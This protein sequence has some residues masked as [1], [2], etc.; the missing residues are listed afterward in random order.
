M[1][2]DGS[3]MNVLM[4]AI[5]FNFLMENEFDDL[6]DSILEDARRTYSETTIEHFMDP[7]NLGPMDGADAFAEFHGPCGDTIG[8]WVKVKDGTLTDVRFITDGCGTSIASG[9]MI[10]EL[11]KGKDVDHAKKISQEDVLTALGGFPQEKE[12]CAMLAIM[13]LRKAIK[14]LPETE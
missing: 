5:T 7:R 1:K 13:S 8:I 12:H 14:S 10:T 9:S 2:T 6:Q 4:L 3:E 11:A